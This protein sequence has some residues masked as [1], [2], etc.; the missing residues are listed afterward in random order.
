[1]GLFGGICLAVLW[2]WWGPWGPWVGKLPLPDMDELIWWRKMWLVWVFVGAWHHL[3]GW[4]TWYGKCVILRG[5]S[6]C[7]GTLVGAQRA[8]DGE[9]TSPRCG[10]VFMMKKN[11]AGVGICGCLTSLVWKHN[12]E[13]GS[14]W[15][16]C[17]AVLG[18]WWGPRGPWM[19]KSPLPDVDEYVEEK[20]CWCG[21][22]WLHDITLIVWKHD[23]ENGSFWGVCLAVLGLWLGP[24]RALD[25]QITPARCGWVS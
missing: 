22:L 13:N 16:V 25:G 21:Y 18:L 3:Y 1:M 19:G 6:G 7:F 11:V 9:I 10:W 15:G 20:C 14:F 4:K 5:I 8:L 17:L 2:L 24:L 12:R 23:R